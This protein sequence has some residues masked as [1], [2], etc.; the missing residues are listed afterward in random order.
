MKRI[1]IIKYILLLILI[2]AVSA[3][4][5]LLA[6]GYNINPQTYKLDKTG[7]IYLESTP[8]DVDVYINGDYKA[9]E[10]SYKLKR[11]FPGRYDVI[12]CNENYYDW[13]ETLWVESEM[14]AERKYIVLFLKKPEAI[15]LTEEEIEFWNKQ[16]ANPKDSWTKNLYIKDNNEIWFDDI[17]ISRLSYNIKKIC[18]YYDK[19]HILYQVD[20]KINIMDVTGTNII[21]L[22]ELSNDELAYFTDD[23]NGES[24]VYKDGDEIYKIKITQSK[25]FI[26]EL[27]PNIL[28]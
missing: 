13:Q 26:E 6:N 12:L 3:W 14:V 18:W 2:L 10:T 27:T 1:H 16:F 23:D 7:M 8:S 15:E 22:A 24:L 21:T 25:G 20:K 17:L 9:D 4:L 5:I 28:K 11:I 19:H